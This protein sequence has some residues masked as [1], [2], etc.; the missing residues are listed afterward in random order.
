MCTGQGSKRTL[1]ASNAG[2]LLCDWSS[3]ALTLREVLIWPLSASG[4]N[5]GL[6][7][8]TPAVPGRRLQPS[9]GREKGPTWEQRDGRCFAHTHTPRAESRN[10]SSKDPSDSDP[11][12]QEAVFLAFCG[13]RGPVPS[14]PGEQAP[15]VRL[16]CSLICVPFQAVVRAQSLVKRCLQGWKGECGLSL[17]SLPGEVL[18]APGS[19]RQLQAR[20]SPN[21]PPLAQPGEAALGSSVRS[22]WPRG[23]TD[24]GRGRWE[25]PVPCSEQPAPC[26]AQS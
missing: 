4:Q 7:T 5:R 19:W 3:Q 25:G 20:T 10:N 12:G 8:Q 1:T 16:P 13:A 18:G 26:W 9:K 6:R 17:A 24:R 11:Q 2:Q 22:A 15:P 14:E 23:R 21:L